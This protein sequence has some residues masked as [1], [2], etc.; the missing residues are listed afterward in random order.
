MKLNSF[1]DEFVQQR[2]SINRQIY[3]YILH[4]QVRQHNDNLAKQFTHF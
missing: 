1:V 4:W 2:V 3:I